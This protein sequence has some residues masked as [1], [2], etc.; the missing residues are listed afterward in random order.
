MEQRPTVIQDF[1]SR[2]Q[3]RFSAFF[4]GHSVL[5]KERYGTPH[6]T[7]KVMHSY[8]PNVAAG[9]DGLRRDGQV[10]RSRTSTRSL[11]DPISS[12]LGSPGSPQ[13]EE[14]W[15]H[16]GALFRPVST[17]APD[18][19][20]ETQMDHRSRGSFSIC[21]EGPSLVKKS[22]EERYCLPTVMN[23]QIRYKIIGSLVSGSLLILLLTIYLAL[24]VSGSISDQSVHIVMIILILFVTM[25]FCHFLIRLCMLSIRLRDRTKRRVKRVLRPADDEELAQPQTPIPIILAR[26]EEM[27][28]HGTG[29]GN[30]S[31]SPVQPPPPAY[32]VWRSSVRA[33]PDLIHWQRIDRQSLRQCEGDTPDLAQHPAMRP[34]SYHPQEAEASS[35]IYSASPLP[36]LQPV[37]YRWE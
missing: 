29:N 19:R 1:C 6:M 25:L 34:P 2:A 27:G 24:A 26:D 4:H 30:N 37:A 5:T 21:Q 14:L 18:P 22:K 20:L 16:R 13:T 36:I 8:R 31:N 28:L 17:L 35:S 12:P 3:V 32:G 9:E 33:D 23:R 15:H 10:S 11:I 7:T